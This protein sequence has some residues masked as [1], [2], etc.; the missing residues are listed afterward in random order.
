MKNNIP[1][2]VRIGL[3]VASILYIVFMWVKKD[4]AGIYASLPA[5][6]AL[7]LLVTTVAVFLVKVVLLAAV[8]LL[9]KWIAGK[10]GGGGK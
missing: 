10:I 2:P 7:P 3:G 9:L 4:V 1:K 5:E 8:I 6:E